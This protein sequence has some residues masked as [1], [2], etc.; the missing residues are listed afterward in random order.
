M[1][2]II[3]FILYLDLLSFFEKKKKKNI[4]IYIYKSKLNISLE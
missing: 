2:V 4:Y 1:K 3:K